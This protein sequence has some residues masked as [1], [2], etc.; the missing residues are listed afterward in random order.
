MR[1][2]TIILVH[3]WRHKVLSWLNLPKTL[4]NKRVTAFATFAEYLSDQIETSLVDFLPEY[5]H[6]KI[7]SIV[8]ELW[9]REG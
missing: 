5:L 9:Q 7:W 3:F 8:V 1:T 6:K 2:R 4:C